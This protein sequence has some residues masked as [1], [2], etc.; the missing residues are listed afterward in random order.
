MD[1]GISLKGNCY[2]IVG[3]ICN[4]F[5]EK[6]PLSMA[7]QQ[8]LEVTIFLNQSLSKVQLLKLEGSYLLALP[9]IVRS[10][11]FILFYFLLHFLEFVLASSATFLVAI[12]EDYP[13][14]CNVLEFYLANHNPSP[15]SLDVKFIRILVK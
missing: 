5:G 6:Q 4:L 2:K 11:S 15:I 13:P 1:Y 7:W 14:P 8:I 10:S 12:L 3:K 9:W